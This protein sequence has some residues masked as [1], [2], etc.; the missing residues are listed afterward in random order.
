MPV[1]KADVLNSSSDLPDCG[2]FP[3]VY[4]DKSPEI[5]QAW[6]YLRQYIYDCTRCG[7]AYHPIISD[8]DRTL[9]R[10]HHWRQ[11]LEGSF[12]F[13]NQERVERLH[14]GQQY[15]IVELS[16]HSLV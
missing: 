5:K 11:I 14:K 4:N 10:F 12:A 6:R 9:T 3:E 1:N 13:Q 7:T 2:K 8:E 15:T 16:H